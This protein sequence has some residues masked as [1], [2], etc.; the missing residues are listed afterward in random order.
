LIEVD[1]ENAVDSRTGRLCILAAA[2]LW[3][4]AGVVAKRPELAN[5]DGP[6]IAVFRSFFAGLIL[7]PLV[8]ADRRQFP[9]ILMPV[10]AAF[11]V[12]V[13]LYLYSLRATTAANAIFLQCSAG[14]WL[15]PLSAWFLRERPDRRSLLALAIAAPGIFTIVVAGHSGT[16]GE[17]LAVAAGL[18]S[19]L[20]Y[21]CVVTALRGLR[22]CDPRWLAAVNNLVGAVVLAV[23]LRLLGGFRLMPSPTQC[24]ILAAFG[25]VQMGIPYALFARGIRSISTVEAGLISLIEPILNPVLVALVI[26]ERP[27]W[28]TIVGGTFLLLGVAA[29][30]LPMPGDPRRG[31]A[32]HASS[33]RKSTS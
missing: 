24:A 17:W 12:M 25:I 30:Y 14:L 10:A 20:G 19:G 11:G 6:T 28:P 15:V 13:G 18:L 29:R 1:S 2:V 9:P 22:A 21:A 32:N 33:G 5:L 3:S 26:G 7:L 23:I 31:V 27:R 8:P 16:A 4:L